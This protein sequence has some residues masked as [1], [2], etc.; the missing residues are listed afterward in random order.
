MLSVLQT[1]YCVGS[2]VLPGDLITL[3]VC[4]RPDRRPAAN[5]TRYDKRTAQA[6]LGT[7]ASTVAIQKIVIA[8]LDQAGGSET[9]SS[10]DKCGCGSDGRVDLDQTGSA[11][12]RIRI[13]SAVSSMIC[14]TCAGV[15][16]GLADNISAATPARLADAAEVP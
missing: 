13:G 8:N 10:R 11:H 9:R 14:S 7:G 16:L 15:R 5:V 12:G 4:F 3:A 1:V 2:D 6:Q